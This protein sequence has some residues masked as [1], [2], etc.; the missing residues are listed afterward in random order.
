MDSEK[1]AKEFLKFSE[2]L[3]KK[4][5][6]VQVNTGEEKQKSGIYPHEVKD[7]IKHC[8]YDLKLNITGLMCIPPILDE[9][10]PHFQMLKKLAIEN[11]VKH[12]SMGMSSDYKI[13]VESGASFIRIG[14]Q[15]FGERK[16]I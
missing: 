15:L 2:T 3:S 13:A 9:P 12:L 11:N 16:L 6:F 14:T 7:F 4:Y 1:L 10:R 5:F 8:I